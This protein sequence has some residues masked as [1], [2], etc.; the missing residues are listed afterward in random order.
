MSWLLHE[1][2]CPCNARSSIPMPI[3]FNP[4][5]Y[6]WYHYCLCFTIAATILLLHY[7]KTIA[8]DKMLRAS[9]FLGADE[10]TTH[11]LRL[12]NILWLPLCQINK[13]GFYFPRRLL[14][15]PILVG[16]QRD[17]SSELWTLV[18][19]FTLIIPSTANTVYFPQVLFHS[20]QI[21]ISFHTICLIIC[22]Q[23]N[24]WDRQ[25]H[26]KLGQS[27]LVVLCVGSTLLTDADSAP[28]HKSASSNLQKWF[29]SATGWLNFGFILREN[30]V[31]CSSYLPFGVSQR[32]L[33]DITHWGL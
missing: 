22:F 2:S 15:F 10:L 31:L 4:T 26:C 5:V 32:I 21:N 20:L 9:L 14:R 6:Y 29:L 19:F 28:Y 7:Y 24:Q 13:F 30:L 8:T 16:H 27:I 33:W 18:Y 12:I 1:L 23:Q 25:P 17:T 3:V 11:V